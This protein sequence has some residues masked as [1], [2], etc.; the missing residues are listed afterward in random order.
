L[1]DG[2]YYQKTYWMLT[3]YFSLLCPAISYNLYLRRLTP[4]LC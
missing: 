2:V 4:A 3:A 1:Q